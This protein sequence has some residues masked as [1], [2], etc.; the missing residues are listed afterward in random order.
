[1][2]VLQQRLLDAPDTF[3]SAWNYIDAYLRLEH[4][5][6]RPALYRMLRQALTARR[7]L[8]LLD[9]LDEAV[10]KRADI[11]LHVVEVLAPQGHVLL[12]T[13][14]PAGVDEARFAAFRRLA[15][16]PLSDAQQERAL[17]QRL[18]AERA[19]ALLTYVRDVMPRDD[20]GQKVTSNPLML[21]MALPCTS[22]GRA[23]ACPGR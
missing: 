10:T 15:L 14:R 6:S 19:A 1:V 5:A 8:L 7:A 2:Q 20:T 22:C 3:A 4:E 13:S 11:E 18:G 12:C 23:W 17:E 21:S 16:A 9:G